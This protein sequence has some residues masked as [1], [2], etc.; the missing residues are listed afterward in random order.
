MH[1][2]H[3]L[4]IQFYVKEENDIRYLSCSMYQR[5]ADMFLG[6]PFNI[7][8]YSLLC[9]IMCEILS[10]TTD[11]TYKPDKLNIYFGYCHIYEN[12]IEAVS[13]QTQ[14]IPYKFPTL[15][16]NKKIMNFDDINFEDIK[17]SNYLYHDP[18]KAEM[19]S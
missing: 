17:I 4:T 7:T 14:R 2:C 19:I 11:F 18:I 15:V 13:I 10:N 1:P 12:H 16:F 9:Y 8:S 3:G 5:S 6:V